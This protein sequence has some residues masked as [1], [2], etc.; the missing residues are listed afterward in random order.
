[1][2]A[3]AADYTNTFRN[4]SRFEASPEPLFQHGEGA[5]WYAL[6]RARLLRQP[7]SNAEI[8]TIMNQTN[9]AIIPRNHLVEAALAR[10]TLS[11]D[12]SGCTDLLAALKD[13]FTESLTFAHFKNPAPPGSEPYQTFC[14]T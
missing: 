10:A 12:Y 13:P 6:W 2:H 14:G 7:H 4:L 8:A 5:A 3:G 1:M 11:A 9:P